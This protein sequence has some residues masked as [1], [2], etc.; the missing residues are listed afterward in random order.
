MFVGTGLEVGVKVSIDTLV[1]LGVD[2][3]MSS[4]FVGPEV[5]GVNVDATVCV[6]VFVAFSGIAGVV[7]NVPV[8]DTSVGVTV[9]SN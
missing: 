8:G 9:N 2:L 6:G 7:V 1:L 4:S 5:T 3:N